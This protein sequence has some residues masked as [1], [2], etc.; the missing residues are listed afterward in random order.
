MFTNLSKHELSIT[1]PSYTS[2]EVIEW[3]E[4]MECTNKLADVL[5]ELVH[6]SIKS[7]KSIKAIDTHSELQTSQS[8]Y[9]TD[10]S[11]LFE[12]LYNWQD[13]KNAI[14]KAENEVK[15]EKKRMLSV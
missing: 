2:K 14:L 9:E 7:G 10:Q 4:I 5:V 12:N 15:K 1:L 6:E 13:S 3:F 8:I 11:N